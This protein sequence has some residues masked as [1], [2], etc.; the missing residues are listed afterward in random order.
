MT[1]LN[2]I[3]GS[4]FPV[5]GLSEEEVTVLFA[6]NSVDSPNP[7]IIGYIAEVAR[8]IGLEEFED[9]TMDQ[10]I[11]MDAATSLVATG[12]LSLYSPKTQ[13]GNGPVAYKVTKIG[14]SFIDNHTETSEE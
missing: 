8:Q 5:V 4:P 3:R 9:F 6:V 2:Y 12:Y 7:S 10:I 11:C 13:Y 14:K 1:E